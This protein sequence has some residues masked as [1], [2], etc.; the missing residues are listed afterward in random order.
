MQALLGQKVD[1][2]VEGLSPRDPNMVRGRTR[3]WRNVIF[4]GSKDSIGSTQTVELAS[5]VRQTF[6]ATCPT[7]L[8]SKILFL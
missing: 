4:P 3:D 8:Y 2:L 6:I 7:S 5:F 1:V